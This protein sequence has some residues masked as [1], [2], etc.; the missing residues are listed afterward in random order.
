MIFFIEIAIIFF[1]FFLSYKFNFLIK[2][3]DLPG[4][5]KIHKQKVLTS[6]GFIPLLISSIIIFYYIFFSEIEFSSYYY[7][8][9]QIWMAPVSLI[10]L[11]LIS[12][13]DDYKYIPFQVRLFLQL[14]IVYLCISLFPINPMSNIQTP[15]FLGSL[16]IKLDIIITIIFWTFVI[17]STNFIDGFDGMYSFQTISNFLGLSVIFF[18]L[19]EEFHFMISILILIIGTLFLFFNFGKKYKMY[20]GDV[21]SIPTGFILGWMLISLAN[22]GYFLTAIILNSLF[23]FDVMFTLVNR[24]LRKKSIFSRHNDF[25]FKKFIMRKGL[26]KYLLWAVPLQIIILIIS[27]ITILQ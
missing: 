8:I 21:G 3:Y 23:L 26:K 15:L 19:N 5:N 16:P 17:N 9:P 14:S 24:I 2:N 18:L 6:G 27:I 25:I 7:M 12:F 13:Y 22:M 20:I 1:S 11:I 4:E 10:I